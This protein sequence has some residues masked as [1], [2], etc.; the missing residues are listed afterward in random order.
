MRQWRSR[1][2]QRRDQSAKL[3]ANTSGPR[4]FNIVFRRWTQTGACSVG[5]IYLAS[6]AAD[7]VAGAQIEATG[8]V[9][10]DFLGA[11]MTKVEKFTCGAR[12]DPGTGSE[13]AAQRGPV[14]NQPAVA[15]SQ[16]AEDCAKELGIELTKKIAAC[17]ELIAQDAKNAAAYLNRGFTHAIYCSGNVPPCDLAIADFSKWIELDPKFGT[18]HA[19]VL[20]GRG[21]S[22]KSKGDKDRARADFSKAIELDPTYASAYLERALLWEFEFRDYNAAVA[23]YDKLIQLQPGQSRYHG[24]RA[25]AYQEMGDYKRA[26]SDV[27]AA[28]AISPDASHQHLL[29]NLKTV[30]ANP[31]PAIECA[32]ELSHVLGVKACSQLIE[33]N[34]NDADAYIHRANLQRGKKQMEQALADYDKAIELNPRQAAYFGQRAQLHSMMKAPDKELADYSKMIEL[35]PK[36]AKYYS[37]RATFYSEHSS[38]DKAVADWTKAIKLDPSAHHYLCDRANDYAALGDAKREKAD[39]KAADKLSDREGY[40]DD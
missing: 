26:I 32:A 6:E 29:A 1:H 23:D 15:Q 19:R 39:M 27:E 24:L 3:S 20:V 28:L 8:A 40:C 38:F 36:N 34:A 22:Y 13:A 37:E 5:I 35:E 12:S 30:V 16:A 14:V 17:T 10:S 4:S 7:C 25:R 18:E 9:E 11:H 21:T 33:K 31:D 2:R